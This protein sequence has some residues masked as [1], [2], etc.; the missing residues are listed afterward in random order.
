MRMTVSGSLASADEG[1]GESAGASFAGTTRPS[2]P[3]PHQGPAAG[4]VSGHDGASA[5][6][7]FQKGSRQAF[8]ARAR[9]GRQT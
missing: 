7:A 9:A 2:T 8:A 3:V 5:G 1:I 4:H 6:S